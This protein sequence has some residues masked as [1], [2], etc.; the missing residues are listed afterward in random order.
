MSSTQR[1]EPRSMRP[2]ASFALFLSAT[3]VSLALTQGLFSRGIAGG[4]SP[5]RRPHPLV[6]CLLR[7]LGLLPVPVS[8]AP[9][10]SCGWRSQI[11]AL[12][13]RFARSV[14]QVGLELPRGPRGLDGGPGAVS[15]FL[16]LEG[17]APERSGDHV[18]QDSPLGPKTRRSSR[19]RMRSRRS[20][21][22]STSLCITSP[23]TTSRPGAPPPS[24]LRRVPAR[25]RR[26]PRTG[27]G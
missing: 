11:G 14:L 7:E 1:R 26:L 3:L 9:M 23:R 21:C 5:A 4:G 20:G 8:L 19:G 24:T 15:R 12:G 27:R 22:P 25:G 2:R 10:R 16:E 18:V 17:A 6:R 13:S